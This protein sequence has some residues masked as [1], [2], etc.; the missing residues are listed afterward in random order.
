M[1]L[2][3]KNIQELHL[4]QNAVA[5]MVCAGLDVHIFISPM[6]AALVADLLLDPLQ[7]GGCHLI[8]PMWPGTRLLDGLLF[9]VTST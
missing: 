4:I 6:G 1:G 7:S 9:P 2:P 8:S 3:L 5:L